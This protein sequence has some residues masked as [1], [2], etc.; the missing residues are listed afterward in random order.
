MTRILPWTGLITSTEIVTSAP[1]NGW[2]NVAFRSP[3]AHHTSTAQAA[4]WATTKAAKAQPNGAK[5]GRVDRRCVAPVRRPGRGAG[6]GAAFEI[7]VR[8]RRIAQRVFLIDRNFHRAFA[9]HV[10]QV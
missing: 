7:A 6:G 9:D 5:Y 10:E 1:S 2:L 8:L 4:I 3:R